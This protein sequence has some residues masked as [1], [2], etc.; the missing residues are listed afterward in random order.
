MS[1]KTGGVVALL[2]MCALSLF[3]VNC[4]SSSSRPAGLLYVLSQAEDDVSSFALDLS[5]GNLSF[6]NASVTTGGL[7]L[8]ISLDPTGATAFVLNQGS[9]TGYTIG[10]DGGLSPSSGGVTLGQTALAMTRD[11]AGAFL[12]VISVPPVPSLADPPLISVFT[13]S[14]GSTT[15][16]P[17]STF[18]L[19]KV[20]TALSVITVS[21]SSKTILFVTNNKDLQ[22]NNDNSISV[23][24]VD[25]TGTLTE[26]LASPYVTQVNPVSVL[27]VNT[28]PAGQATGGFFTYVG[29]QGATAGGLSAFQLCAI[30]NATCSQQDVD[31]DLLLPVGATQSIG[32]NPVAMV[33]DP[34]NTFLFVACEGSN[35]VHGFRITTSTGGLT[36][37]SPATQP[38]GSMPVA[39][40]IRSNKDL[41]A[42]FLYVSNNLSSNITGFS[43]G[44]TT[45]AMSNPITVTFTPGAP[46]GMAAR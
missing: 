43:V 10:S 11:A 26:S 16:T 2:G 31:N 36:V 38:T 41:T 12:F 37:L 15:L 45:G 7:P 29:N 6:I 8:S 22:S 13:T 44:A 28:N 20:P 27:A 21:S 3:L 32:Q 1:K 30:V 35:A 19:T 39:M 18:A 42:E 4:G 25:S 5:S 24:D 34:N 23:Y 33:V 14:P 9:I 17:T 40:A 46:A